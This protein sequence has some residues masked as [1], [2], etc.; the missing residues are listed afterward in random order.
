MITA[1][2]FSRNRA[3]QLDALLTSMEKYA[4]GIFKPVIICRADTPLFAEGY[5]RLLHTHRKVRLTFQG[6]FH[7]DTFIAVS[8]SLSLVGFF[9]D[10]D[11]FFR[12]VTEEALQ[13]PEGY[14]C[15]SPRLGKNITYCYAMAKEQKP[16]ELDFDYP[17]STDGH[18]FR[19]DELLHRIQY[20]GYFDNPNELEQS[21]HE[22]S[23]ILSSPQ[24]IAYAEHS[25]LVGI[26]HNRVQTAFKN[27]DGGGNYL[28]LNERFLQGERIDL[29]AMDFSNVIGAHQEIPYRFKKW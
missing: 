12:P 1:I 6:T 9:V 26:P 21:L 24:L 2:I 14:L 15:F 23:R 8:E 11:V 28:E 29:D 5:C 17:M 27:R 19:R 18:I 4:P 10:D 13:I 16:G 7:T 20:A 3:M 25:S 22:Q